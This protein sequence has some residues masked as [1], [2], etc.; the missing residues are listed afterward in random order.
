MINRQNSWLGD[1][2]DWQDVVSFIHENIETFLSV[3]IHA[4]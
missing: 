4:F 1:M 2:L 3:S